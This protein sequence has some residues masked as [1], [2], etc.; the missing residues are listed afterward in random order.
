[1]VNRHFAILNAREL[2][3][4]FLQTLKS[5]VTVL[6][7]LL[8]NLSIF[9]VKS[10]LNFHCSELLIQEHGLISQIVV[11][12]SLREVVI[13]RQIFFYRSQVMVTGHRLQLP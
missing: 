9:R 11:S 2:R 13:P 5:K 12:W 4:F 3:F 6:P 8:S 1:M 7:V 10:R